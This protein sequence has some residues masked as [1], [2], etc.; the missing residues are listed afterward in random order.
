MNRKGS[1]FQ[2]LASLD[3]TPAMK[4]VPAL[5]PT[6]VNSFTIP[7]HGSSLI[8]VPT[9]KTGTKK[10]KKVQCTLETAKNSPKTMQNP[11]K[12]T[13]P[14]VQSG[15]K[16]TSPECKSVQPG[17]K[18]Y[19][20]KDSAMCLFTTVI[21]CGLLTAC[22]STR[23]LKPG[24]SVLHSGTATN[25]LQEFR[26]EMRQPENPAQSAA[27]HYEKVTETEFPL[28][29][30]SKVTEI[31]QSQ[32]DQGRPVTREKTII[33]TEPTIQKVRQIEKAGTTIGAAQK[34]TAREI[35][36]KLSS[37]KGVVWVGVLL[38]LFG[39]A[40]LFYPPLRAII[41]SV[42]T[43]M[44]ITGGGVAL[45]TLPSFVVGNE[46]LIFGG[47]AAVTVTWFLAHRH[48]TARGL[49]QAIAQQQSSKL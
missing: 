30:G 3:N 37:L 49:L 46:L 16:S 27:Q 23:P 35:G 39:L 19:N 5:A 6:Q 33:L 14:R 36:A 11:T 44:A 18:K 15:A 17:T 12:S 13:T 38:F 29:R 25:G 40:T 45:I 4:L 31:V 26:S 48:G 8:S 2:P 10:Y 20:V 43:S 28:A 9:L 41:G 32:D 1:L 47:V 24:H 42:T 7:S 34:D 22:S 21:L